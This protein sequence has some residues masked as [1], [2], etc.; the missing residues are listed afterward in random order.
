M[1]HD[2]DTMGTWKDSHGIYVVAERGA[3]RKD[4]G[5][6]PRSKVTVARHVY[7]ASLRL[8]KMKITEHGK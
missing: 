1:P 8:G 7:G 3:F 5:E 6:T 4:N 2:S